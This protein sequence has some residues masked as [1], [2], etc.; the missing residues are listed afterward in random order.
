M[1]GYLGSAGLSMCFGRMCP[2]EVSGREKECIQMFISMFSAIQ[3]QRQMS[4]I[5]L[6]G[7]IRDSFEM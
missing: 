6:H 7:F 5:L 2:Y 1:F 3:D 4:F